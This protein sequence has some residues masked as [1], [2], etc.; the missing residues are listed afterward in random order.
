MSENPNPTKCGNCGTLNPPGQEFCRECHA[1]LT[2]S[3]DAD[4]LEP[5]PEAQEEPRRFA[6]EGGE[7]VPEAGLMGG[8]GGEPIPMPAERRDQDADEPPRD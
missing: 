6:D 1:P 5:T 2:I 7:D 4:A 3:A 8:L